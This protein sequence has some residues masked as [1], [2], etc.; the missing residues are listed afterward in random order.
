MRAALLAII[1]LLGAGRVLAATLEVVVRDERGNPVENAVAYA[2]PR[3]I[4]APAG[5]KRTASIEQI[6]K[7]FVPHVTVVQAGTTV[8]FPNRDPIRHHVYS[9]SP[10]KAFE[11]KLYAGTP[12]TPVLFDK[13]GEV[14]LGCNI[15]DNM[16]AFVLVVE[17]PYFAKTPREGI[18]RIDSL[19]A[20]EY[21]VHVWHP[22][23]AAAVPVRTVRLRA[24]ETAPYPA[25][26]T[27][28][29]LPARAPAR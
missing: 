12:P 18:A 6:D 27:L 19:P 17:T 2:S 25:A 29:A 11:I 21:D 14:V 22:A 5:A 10:A 9:F 7:T 13:P 4:P 1:A 15:H 26:V 28:K 16:L 8:Q 20:G 23:Q 24:D 3:G